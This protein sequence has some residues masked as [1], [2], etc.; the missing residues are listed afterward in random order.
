MGKMGVETLVSGLA[1]WIWWFEGR[2]KFELKRAKEKSRLRRKVEG[3]WKSLDAPTWRR[4]GITTEQFEKAE[5]EREQNESKRKQRKDPWWGFEA[6]LGEPQSSIDRICG[7]L[8]FP[9]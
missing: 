6:W 9:S 4:V 8:S 7:F 1:L 2:G 3:A 5:N